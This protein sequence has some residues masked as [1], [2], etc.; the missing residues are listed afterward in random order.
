MI[1]RVNTAQEGN[2]LLEFDMSDLAKGLYI[3]SFTSGEESKQVRV[4]VE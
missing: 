4:V 2:N 1:E 3:L